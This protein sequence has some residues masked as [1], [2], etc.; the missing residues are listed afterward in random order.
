[1]GVNSRDYSRRTPNGIDA[2]KAVDCKTEWGF[3]L[4]LKGAFDIR[5]SWMLS[6]EFNTPNL[7]GG[8]HQ[9]FCWG[10]G[11]PGDDPLWV[12]LEGDRLSAVI[13]NT[14][15]DRGQAIDYHLPQSAI[16]QWTDLKLFYDGVEG[17]LELYINRR[18]KE[19]MF[20]HGTSR[21]PGEFLLEIKS[22]ANFDWPWSH[23]PNETEAERIF[24][25]SFPAIHAHLEQFRDAA[26]KRLDKGRFWWEL[27]ACGYWDAFD[28]HKII[29]P[30][31]SKLPRFS[32]DTQ[33]HYLGNTRC[34]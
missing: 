28:Q 27:R 31:I 4:K 10:D 32:M 22:S 23:A 8:W 18:L 34:T 15:E 19:P 6:L 17:K 16:G 11:A 21:V 2:D 25:Q 9:I 14:I 20:D 12:R 1:M 24:A 30:D 3:P 13:E 29:W 7:D 5:K 33:Q 26:K